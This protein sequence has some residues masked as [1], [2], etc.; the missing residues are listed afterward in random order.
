MEKKNKDLCVTCEHYWED[1]PM[2]LENVISHCDKV[3]EK[4]GFKGMN[5]F[6]IRV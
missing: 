1:F 4:Y 3:D 6:L 2:P 5:M